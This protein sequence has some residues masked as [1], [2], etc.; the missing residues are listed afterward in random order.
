MSTIG[1]NNLQ[2][3]GKDSIEGGPYSNP[4]PDKIDLLLADG[5]ELALGKA[6]VKII[7]TPGH[8]PGCISFIFL[9]ADNG[10]PH[11]VGIMGGGG[12]SNDR[13]RAYLY[14]SSVDYFM[15]FSRQYKCDIGF[16][17]HAWDYYKELK[18]LRGR[19]PGQANP[20]IIGADKYDSVYLE[21]FR[22]RARDVI[23]KLPPEVLP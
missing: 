14:L 9:C 20:L 10:I 15:Q 5:Q 3:R 17:V 6:T 16:A 21:K 23:A 8:S 4:R 22:Q 18:T 1:W 2:T 13:D 19:K 11:V 12:V 7:Y